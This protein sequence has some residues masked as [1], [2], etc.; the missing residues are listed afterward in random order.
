[1]KYF[2]HQLKSS[3]EV[4][5][6][7]TVHYFELSKDFT[8]PAESHDFWELHYVDKGSITAL[9]GENL[10]KLSQGELFFHKPNSKHQLVADG[11]IAANVCVVSFE[12]EGQELESIAGVKIKITQSQKDILGKLLDE[13][14]TTFDI[15]NSN[16]ELNKLTL[17]PIRNFGD[18]QLIKIY[19]EQ[20]IIDVLRKTVHQKPILNF[21]AKTQ[22][23]NDDLINKIIEFLYEN[24]ANNITLDDIC[25]EFHFSKGYISRK[26]LAVTGITIISYFN[27]IKIS[28]AKQI[29][30]SK[31][32]EFNCI[33]KLADG[34]GFSTDSYFCYTF[35]KI[36]GMTPKEY[37][38]SVRKYDR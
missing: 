13:A 36:T 9:S 7:I 12:C 5:K 1:M 34:L 23:Y 18:L 29:I 22:E 15:S 33:S 24:V 19:L 2:R 27:N 8:Y 25:E 6:L 4:D 31:N 17:K 14:S 30:R 28:L 3:I 26:F 16:P 10:V 38:K 37:E 20:L 35:K 11:Q 32:A 21:F